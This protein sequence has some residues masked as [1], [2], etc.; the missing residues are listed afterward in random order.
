MIPEHES[1]NEHKKQYSRHERDTQLGNHCWYSTI[2]EWIQLIIP[3]F[4]EFHF[5][6][7][8]LKWVHY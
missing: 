8:M 2:I 3:S 6:K 7:G 1:L 5:L 4:R